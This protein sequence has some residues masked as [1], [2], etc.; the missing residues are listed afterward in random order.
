MQERVIITP[1]VKKKEKE[2]LG[3]IDRKTGFLER[4]YNFG[5][6]DRI[7]LERELSTVNAWISISFQILT[8]HP[9]SPPKT[10]AQLEASG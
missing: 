1:Y 10:E 7:N 8:S 4:I 2:T 3:E 9:P 6:K 5:V